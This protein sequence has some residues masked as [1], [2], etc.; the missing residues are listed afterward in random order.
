[1]STHQRLRYR[2]ELD[3]LRAIAVGAVVMQH[4]RVGPLSGGFLGVDIFLVLSGFLIT[5]IVDDDIAQGKH[6]LVRFY[7]RR[8]RR[9]V[10]ALVLVVLVCLPFAARWLS[11]EQRELFAGSL[12][13][14]FAFASNVYWWLH[15]GY[16]EPDAQTQPLLHTWSLAL[17]EQFY[18]VFPFVLVALARTSARVRFAV[19]SALA[20]ASLGVAHV[21]ATRWPS[22]NFY[23][24]PGRAWELLAGSLLALGMRHTARRPSR[25]V[26]DA[27]GVVA[28]LA[29]FA[30]LLLMTERMPLPGLWTV[31]P[32]A[33][34]VALLL[35]ASPE[36]LAGRL[37]AARPLVWVGLI[38]YSAYLW[39]QPILAFAQHRSPTE[40][41]A[42]TRLALAI[43]TLV[44]AWLSWR[45]VEQPFRD[46]T[47]WTRGAVFRWATVA[48]VG[49]LLLGAAGTQS[50][51]ALGLS[52]S[53]RQTEEDLAWRVS[54]NWGL[55]ERCDTVYTEAAVCRTGADPQVAVWG[56]SYGMHMVDAVRALPRAP[57]LVQFTR[58]ECVPIL[59][60]AT[61]APDYA[62]W[63]AEECLA[64][65]AK[66]MAY[67]ARTP[68]IR[69]VVIATP[70][71]NTM[72]R[73][74]DLL[75]TDGQIVPGISTGRRAFAATL[76]SLIALHVRPIVIAP[77][78][79]TRFDF[80]A[81]LVKASRF[82]MALSVCDFPVATWQRI[83]KSTIAFLDTLGQRYP[84]VWPSASLCDGITC[85]VSIN[86]IFVYRD[87][88]HLSREGSRL[89]GH[90]LPFG[91]ALQAQLDSALS[92]ERRGV[93]N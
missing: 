80:G 63:Q 18:L 56:D 55:N 13:S 25:I 8:V 68:S 20:I 57:A 69:A 11:L 10:P 74:N 23:L 2:P 22:A 5:W 51:G 36:T 58:S 89:L 45:Y 85:H 88:G 79:E 92:G 15:T 39:H 64:H 21:G 4:A 1:M 30:S 47:R 7:E 62:Q 60:M 48:T 76:D 50:A 75:T 38:S 54:V 44:P 71:S 41:S 32:V 73:D 90:A 40:L 14:V 19:L 83:Q 70:F 82:Q 28:L 33:A 6:T 29:L 52:R 49:F 9:I 53:T 31:I 16:F 78:P 67:I 27:V 46:R 61:H 34:T 26:A 65:N 91:V 81:C 24:L 37:L 72:D 86:G 17:E 66:T 93:L 84:V 87:G 43:G 12:T 77:P 59:G 42:S 3:G 35:V